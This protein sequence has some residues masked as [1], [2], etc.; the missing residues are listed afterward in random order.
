MLIPEHKY[1]IE[2]V[3]PPQYT[4]DNQ[5]RFKTIVLKKPGFTDEFGDKIGKDDLFECK[6]W[7]DR[8]EQLPVLK[9]GDK[10]KAMLNLSGREV[11][12]RN[13]SEIYYTMNLNIKQIDLL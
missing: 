3:D 7:N 4:Q 12:D 6:V 11:L 8:I 9:K 5:F 1:L 10:V 13:T 2:R